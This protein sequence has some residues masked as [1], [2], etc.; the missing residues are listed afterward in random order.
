MLHPS[1]VG[2]RDLKSRSLTRR[3]EHKRSSVLLLGGFDSSGICCRV[4]EGVVWYVIRQ[5]KTQ[6]FGN[7]CCS[8]NQSAGSPGLPPFP[9]KPLVGRRSYEIYPLRHNP[10]LPGSIGG[11]GGAES[12]CCR[13]A[14]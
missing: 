6:G 1:R 14:G 11:C 10:L 7:H 8:E 13:D 4:W 2:C 3:G 5:W 9:G 12:T